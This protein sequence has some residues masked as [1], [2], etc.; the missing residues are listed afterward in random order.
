MHDYKNVVKFRNLIN[1]SFDKHD[2][3]NCGEVFEE[4]Y[5][6]MTAKIEF[7]QKAFV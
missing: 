1:Y 2:A 4:M 5:G 6:K 3:P 7:D